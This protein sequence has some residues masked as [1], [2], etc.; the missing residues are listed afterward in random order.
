MPML[1]K[2]FGFLAFLLAMATTVPAQDR[3]R[4]YSVGELDI[5][6]IRDADVTMEKQLLPNLEAFPEF[7]AVFENGP[8]PTVDQT[9]FFKNG[10]HQVLIDAGWGKE[11]KTEGYT[12]DLLHEAGI[13]DA[14]ITDILLTHMDLDH[15]GGLLQNG[16]PVYPNATLWLSR[17]EYEAWLGGSITGRPQSSVDL[18]KKVAAVYKVQQFNYGDEIMPGVI[19]VDASGHTPGHTAY[20]ITSGNAKMTIAGDILHIAPVQ[21]ARPDLST[22][23][24]IDREKAAAARQHLLNRAAEEKSLFAGMHFPMISDVHKISDKGYAMKQP[25]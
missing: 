20:D 15:I 9:F 1:P 16:L 14:G 22:I 6:V 2:L 25:R 7:V 13:A 5:M 3:T 8:V 10:D 12:A 18:A 24:D 19:S 17:P 4:H 21:L 11:L 23:Y